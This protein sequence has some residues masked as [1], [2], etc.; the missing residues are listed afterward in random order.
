VNRDELLGECFGTADLPW[1]AK[2]LSLTAP[3]EGD[4]YITHVRAV[5][6][7]DYRRCLVRQIRPTGPGVSDVTST[8]PVA[9]LCHVCTDPA[10]RGMG[11]AKALIESALEEAASHRT[12]SYAAVVATDTAAF[13]ERFGFRAPM[14]S[15]HGLLVRPLGDDDVMLSGAWTPAGRG[16]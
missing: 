4:A 9:V 13:F 8:L 16:W 2:W 10:Y 7:L 12:V 6:G 1:P 15:V 3:D 5:V 14:A 11:Y